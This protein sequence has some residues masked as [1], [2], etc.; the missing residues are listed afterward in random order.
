MTET[1][2]E[3][4]T[5]TVWNMRSP[6]VQADQLASYDA[7]RARCPVAHGS[8]GSWTV[9]GHAD[10]VAILEDP[11]TFSNEVSSHLAVPN[12]FDAPAHAAYRDVIDRYFTAERL[13][14]FE[15]VCR[16]ICADLVAG[17]AHDRDIEVMATLGD[18]VATDLQCAFMGWPLAMREPLEGWVRKNHAAS[19]SGDRNRMAEV[20]EEFDSFIRA[21]LDA[22]RAD[23]GKT[24]DPTTR[25]LAETVDGRALTDEEIVSI[26]RNWTVGELGT[27]SAAVGI[28]LHFLA[29]HPEEQRRIRAGEWDL[30]A[31]T[32]EL[33]RLGAPLVANRRRTTTPVTIG[34]QEIPAEEKIVVL[35][36][37][38]NRDEAVFPDPDA[39]NPTANRP[40]NLVYGRGVHY[41]PGAGLAR[42]ELRVLLEELF[43][44]T[45]GIE[46]GT[47][48]PVLAHF[49]AGG[50]QEVSVRLR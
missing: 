5:E 29:T 28:I 38:A 33:Q 31:V 46:A 32:D 43:A 39:F 37:S 1:E 7:M 20:A 3:T 9:F 6:Q 17:L 22:R 13:A 35:W 49:P 23:P 2:T 42:L 40:H 50:Y 25:L 41:C 15:P 14:V 10:T 8:D 48:A 30:D 12:G 34:G 4:D 47:V 27:I 44:A 21:E 45:T 24:D 36:A 18:P 26:I 16:A 11:D 19:R